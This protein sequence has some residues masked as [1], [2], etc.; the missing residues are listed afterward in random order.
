MPKTITIVGYEFSELNEQA[1]ARV[2]QWYCDIMDND[3]WDTTYE[4]FVI[5]AK[6]LGFTIPTHYSADPDIWFDTYPWSAGFSARWHL[7]DALGAEKKL[8]E[9]LTDECLQKLAIVLE[10]EIAKFAVEG[11]ELVIREGNVMMPI[12]GNEQGIGKDSDSVEWSADYEL[13]E[14]QTAAACS[15]EI[16][17][18]ATA[19]HLARWLTKQLE[20]EYEYQTSEENIKETCDANEWLFDENGKLL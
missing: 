18:E 5:V 6:A 17:V 9:H 11:L 8:A 4:D 14:Q 10:A 1:R 12:H 16:T 20:A 15:L 3:W 2:R 7:L 13:S 19:M